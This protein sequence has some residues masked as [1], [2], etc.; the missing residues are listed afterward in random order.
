M[1]LCK[2]EIFPKETFMFGGVSSKP[3]MWKATL[4]SKYKWAGLFSVPEV[5]LTLSTGL[6]LT[7]K[8]E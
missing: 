7:R 4:F 1:L 6:M 3:L 8:E 2:V 5:W